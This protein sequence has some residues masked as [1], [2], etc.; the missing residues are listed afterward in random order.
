[1]PPASTRPAAL[2]GP[3]PETLRLFPSVGRDEL[4]RPASRDF[5]VARL[6]EEG[7]RR[8]LFWLTSHVPETELA[9]WI[10]RRGTRQLSRR[11]L[12]FWSLLLDTPTDPPGDALWPL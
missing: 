10:E 1:M 8:D 4:A 11:S 3:C 2:S 12:A 5:L 7:D 9:R 6:L